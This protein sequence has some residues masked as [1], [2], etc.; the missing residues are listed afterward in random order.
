MAPIG[1][2]YSIRDCCKGIVE[3]PWFVGAVLR[4]VPALSVLGVLCPSDP[5]VL[6]V[7]ILE[8]ICYGLIG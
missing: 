3:I 5:S 1:V 6:L 7:F 8:S 4:V 2:W